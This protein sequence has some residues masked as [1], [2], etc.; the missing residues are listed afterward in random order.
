V[1]CRQ[2]RNEFLT[3][4]ADGELDARERAAAEE[5]V[6][7]CSA[8]RCCLNEERGLKAMIREHLGIIKT[9]ASVRAAIRSTLAQ[10][11]MRRD[12]AGHRDARWSRRSLSIAG[13]SR[14]ATVARRLR[15]PR[16]LTQA[17]LAIAALIVVALFAFSGVSFRKPTVRAVPEFDL[18]I[19]KYRVFEHTFIPN[20]PVDHT[21][22]VNGPY[23]AWVVPA[24]NVIPVTEEFDD[25]ARSYR[26]VK[27]PDN[28]F[29]F[30]SAGYELAGGRLDHLAD[31]RPV[32]YTLYQGG[33]GT[34]LSICFRDASL[35]A[36]EGAAQWFGMHAFYRYKG[37]AICLTFY[38]TGHF[39]SILVAQTALPVF[40]RD[41]A[42]AER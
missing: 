3:P 37:Y 36:P 16:L 41:V 9:P 7:L 25:V 42:Y 31:G 8:C 14:I 4:H 30:E 19:S 15:R 20:V 27:M 1:E 6:A 38:P 18:A 26:E 33:S 40:V 39:V 29:D 35:A 5:H 13:S 21:D 24:D 11:A 2:Y 17:S 12:D 10:A 34:I 22:E 28:L 32:T 23:Y